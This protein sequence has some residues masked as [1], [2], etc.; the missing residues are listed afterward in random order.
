MTSYLNSRHVL[1][2]H[3]IAEDT[4]IEQ[5]KS[6]GT[7][8]NTDHKLALPKEEDQFALPTLPTAGVSPTQVCQISQLS[9]AACSKVVVD[10]VHNCS[11]DQTTNGLYLISIYIS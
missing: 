2:Y 8:L 10:L 9:P 7:S 3:K 11:D 5:V 4:G 6:T 1:V